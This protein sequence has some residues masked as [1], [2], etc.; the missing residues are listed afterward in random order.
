MI[1]YLHNIAY[2]IFPVLV[3]TPKTKQRPAPTDRE[4]IEQQIELT[5]LKL[6]A[7]H[8]AKIEADA[9]LEFWQ[10]KIV[11]LKNLRPED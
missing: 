11:A 8:F 5:K 2:S 3:P 4:I 10:S 7:A 1:S 6:L 9:T